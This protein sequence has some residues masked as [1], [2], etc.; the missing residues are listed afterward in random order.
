M[1]FLHSFRPRRFTLVAL[2]FELALGGLGLVLS[3][4][5]GR[6]PAWP[7]VPGAGPLIGRDVGL[8]LLAALPLLAGLL[9]IQGH[10]AGILRQ[11]RRT[12]Q[13]DVV[14]LFHGTSTAGLLAISAAAGIGEELL[15][16]GFLQS[17]VSD[18]WGPLGGAWGGLIVAS[19]VFGICHSLCAAYA[20]VATAIGLVL[21][22]LYLATGSLVAP[23][24]THA[25]YDFLALLYLL[26]GTKGTARGA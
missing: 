12:V 8:G 19:V 10:P 9:V 23:I 18:G 1:D 24:T 17:A 22:A 7:S 14:P 6:G 25:A 16:R 21:G 26:H 13:E 11:L 5:F 4:W 15:F 20:V 3:R 2:A